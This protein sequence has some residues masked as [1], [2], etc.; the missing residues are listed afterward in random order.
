[1]EHLVKFVLHL[2]F[3]HYL[4]YELDFNKTSMFMI[5]N[6]SIKILMRLCLKFGK[7][8]QFKVSIKVLCQEF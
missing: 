5:I 7:M 1:M 6:Q 8:N 2:Y 3:I 4:L